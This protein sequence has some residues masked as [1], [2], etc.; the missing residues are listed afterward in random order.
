[1]SRSPYQVILES[2]GQARIAIGISKTDGAPISMLEAMTMGAFPIQSDTE[3]T[4]EWLTH[5]TNGLLVD[6]DDVAA[7]EQ[8]IR[9][10]LADDTLVDNAA[11][12]NLDLVS[13]KMDTTVVKPKVV[14]MYKSIVK[15][16]QK[17]EQ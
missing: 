10:A 4:A 16:S 12:F 15:R 6:P 8:A 7:I 3:S 17:G 5:E 1:M 14:E 13:Q 9:R 11:E 2:F